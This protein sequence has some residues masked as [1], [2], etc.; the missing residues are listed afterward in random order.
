VIVLIRTLIG[1]AVIY[2]VIKGLTWIGKITHTTAEKYCT[3]TEEKTPWDPIYFTIEDMPYML[4]GLLTIIVV[5]L[6]GGLACKIG[7]IFL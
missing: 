3:A 1:F 5:T 2:G 6:A 4:V 7:G